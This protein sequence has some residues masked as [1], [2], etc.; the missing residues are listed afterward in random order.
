MFFVGAI[1]LYGWIA[2]TA[3]LGYGNLIELHSLVSF[4]IW[5]LIPN[6][7]FFGALT[8]F[9]SSAIRSRVIVLLLS[10]AGIVIFFWLF[11]RLP[12]DMSS[13]LVTT[14]G[15]TLFPSE[16]APRFVSAEILVNRFSLLLLTAG[17]VVL[18]GC[19]WRRP[20][21]NRRLLS[22][23]GIC[24][25]VLSSLIIC[26]SLIYQQ[27][28][29]Q[30]VRSWVQAH[31]AL[32]LRSFPDITS[33]SGNVDIVPGRKIELDLTVEMIPPKNN[34]RDFVVLA[35][36][37][38]YRISDIWLEDNEIDDHSFEQG[39]LQIPI[40]AVDEDIV[41]VRIKARGHPDARFAYL[42]S[43]VKTKDIAG[44]KVR[45]L[46]AMGTES[47]IFHPRFVV[48]TSGIK[49]YPTSDAATGENALETRPEDFYKIDLTVS[50][51]KDWLVAGPGHCELVSTDESR[52]SKFRIAPK[53]PVPAFTLVSSKFERASAVVQDVEFEVL[54][55][56]HH[57]RRFRDLSEI[58][59]P[60][61]Y[62]IAS[63]L[64]HVKKQGLVYPYEQFSLVEVPTYLRVY[65]GGWNMGTIMGPPGMVLMRESSL[66]NTKISI[67]GELSFQDLIDMAEDWGGYTESQILSFM[68]SASDLSAYFKGNVFGEHP[69]IGFARNFVTYQASPTGPGAIVLSQVM[70]EVAQRLVF[71]RSIFMPDRI[72]PGPGRS[73]IFEVA[74]K[75][76]KR[77][78][79]DLFDFNQIN[80]QQSREELAL[81]QEGKQTQ[82]W[83]DLEQ[84]TLGELRLDQAPE[85]SFRV[86]RLKSA[87]MSRILI[88]LLGKDSSARL[89]GHL[90][91]RQR[92]TS[93]SYD[94]LLIGAKE[95]DLDLEGSL[96]NWL[97]AQG[98]P[99]FILAE[100][101]IKRLPD[102]EGGKVF[103]ASLIVHNAE[104][105]D[106][107]AKVSW[108]HEQPAGAERERTRS[109]SKAFLVRGNESVRLSIDTHWPRPIDIVYLEP[110]L[111]LN[112]EAVRIDIPAHFDVDTIVNEELGPGTRTYARDIDWSPPNATEVVIDDLDQGFEIVYENP[113]RTSIPVVSFVSD[114]LG[115]S[116]VEAWDHGLP[117]Y[118]PERG[119]QPTKQRW[120]RRSDPRAFGKYRRTYAFV[121]AGNADRPSYAKFK[122]KLP[123]TGQWKLE[124][125]MPVEALGQSVREKSILRSQEIPTDWYER[126]TPGI[127]LIEVLIGEKSEVVEFDAQSAGYGWNTIGEFDVGSK[128]TEV[129]ISG[130]S[131]R[132][133]IYADAIRWV[134]PMH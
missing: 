78:V 30:E 61:K 112:H 85:R 101:T 64:F 49:W 97:N 70:E 4:L 45:N 134:P 119:V 8:I 55:T 105:T 27:L 28:R 32:E 95:V 127:T 24:S 57:Q 71:D 33:I 20:L 60:L 43:A 11:C 37:P 25:C 108:L 132:E 107:F 110:Y 14:T 21:P 122:A 123:T 51:P 5:D 42:D 88:D 66:P 104:P 128:L 72:G 111:S 133:T 115:T 52:R 9:L 106:G 65:G 102:S 76:A 120:V 118:V 131:D 77:S 86:I 100:P 36:N 18:A 26:G 67:G 50:V 109:F 91:N 29:Q 62:R 114:L 83:I 96:G 80:P 87:A 113:P 98:L 124:Y 73:F 10:F 35:L 34:S 1:V 23:V 22:V 94:D 125:H 6:L 19:G 31:D 58:E 121:Y 63:L 16:I 116:K 40:D 90:A 38:G 93:Y 126:F 74:L 68:H 44:D 56:K 13:T 2:E 103:Q 81:L 46:F 59:N 7:A 79:Y 117:I 53:N 41:S 3:G 84:F 130:A 54:Y 75:N 47:F 15:G 12:V 92:G 82:V 17:F 99:G 48:L 89:L 69:T 129:W 39:I